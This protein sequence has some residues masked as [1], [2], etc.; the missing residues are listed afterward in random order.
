ILENNQRQADA[1]EKE[2]RKDALTERDEAVISDVSPNRPAQILNGRV[3]ID[4]VAWPVTGVKAAEREEHK[5]LQAN[6][7]KQC[8]LLENFVAFHV[9]DLRFGIGF[10]IVN[11]KILMSRMSKSA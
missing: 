10:Q 9:L 7:Q 5:N 11:K 8:R 2:D 4:L 1:G 3:R 6:A